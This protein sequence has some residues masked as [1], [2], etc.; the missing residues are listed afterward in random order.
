MKK[1]ILWVAIALAIVVMFSLVGTIP[2]HSMTVGAM[3]ETYARI[4]LYL[5]KNG[6]LPPDL[7]GLPVRKTHINRTTDGWGNQLLYSINQDQ[8]VTLTSLGRDERPGGAG[9][10]V[11]I[12]R[13][14]RL[15]DGR[16]EEIRSLRPPD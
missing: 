3:T 13:Q 5:D 11:D 4:N 1:A 6:H 12:F 16:L 15:V 14:Y 7:T 2:P 10:D 9:D 8:T